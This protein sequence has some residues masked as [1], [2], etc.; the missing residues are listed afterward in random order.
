MCKAGRPFGQL[1]RNAIK[2]MTLTIPPSLRMCRSRGIDAIA[3]TPNEIDGQTNFG[4]SWH[5]LYGNRPIIIKGTY[6]SNASVVTIVGTILVF[7]TFGLEIVECG[8][9][10][11]K[12]V[13]SG[14]SVYAAVALSRPEAREQVIRAAKVLGVEVRFLDFKYGELQADVESK[15]K[16][17]RVIR[18]V[19]PDIIITQDP[20]P[21][22]ADLDPDRRE[23]MI[24]YFEA[25][26]LASRDFAPEQF[27]EGLREHRFK[28][29]YYLNPHHPNCVVDI[30]DVFE[31]KQRAV[32]ELAYQLAFTAKA[33]GELMPKD[34]LAS[35]IPEYSKYTS[36]LERGLE[37][38]REMNKASGLFHGILSHT[39]CALAEPFRR[40]GMFT[41]DT[42]PLR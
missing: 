15:K 1:D 27:E 19:R 12:H 6:L 10:L 4:A 25:L 14:G 39:R 38:H 37:L 18:E 28:S 42:L 33:I 29:L 32:S 21:S 11:A 41:F 35:I 13:K 22:L 36:D 3:D 26:S 40:E 24:L 7:A 2:S 16:L 31:L 20:E 8:G 5:T 17:V 23:A 9:T 34:R 30:S